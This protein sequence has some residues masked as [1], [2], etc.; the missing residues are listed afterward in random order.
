[1]LAQNTNQ[2]EVLKIYISKL[3]KKYVG[4]ADDWLE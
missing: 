4:W 1:M 3:G 2:S